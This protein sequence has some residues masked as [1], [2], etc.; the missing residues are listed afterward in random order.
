MSAE[1]QIPGNVDAMAETLKPEKVPQS[2]ELV[3]LAE[4]SYRFAVADDGR[5]FA[6]ALD[7]PNLAR[8]LRGGDGLRQELARAYYR[9]HKRVPS[10]T[11]L[12]DALT[13]VEGI[14]S[15]AD[16]EPLALRVA[17][18]G[19]SIVLDLGTA[20][21]CAVVVDRHGWQ[22]VDRSPVVFRR[23]ELTKALP[24]PV[25][26]GQL[27]ELRHVVNVSDGSW[28]LLAG[29]LV[30]SLLPDIPHPIML[31][32]GL[33]GAGKST[34]AANIAAVVD[35]SAAPLQSPPTD[36]ASWTLNA[37]GSWLVALD[38]LSGVAG[39]LSD[40]LCR[41]VTGD[42]RVARQLYSDSSLTVVAIRRCVLL[43]TIDAGALRGDLA[44]RLL[45]VELERIAPTARRTDAELRRAADDMAPRVLGSLLDLLA[46]VLPIVGTVELRLKPRMADFA[47][48]L[49]AI[50]KVTGSRSLDTYMAQSDSLA[51]DVVAD[52]PVASAVVD[53]MS[54]HE[55]WTGTPAA[56]LDT[57]TRRTF[58]DDKARRPKQWPSTAATLSGALK[59]A[60][61][62]LQTVGVIV[63]TGHTG[64]G[65]TKQ[66]SV[67]L[68]RIESAPAA[69][70]PPSPPS[71]DSSRLSLD[72][73]W[74]IPLPPAGATAEQGLFPDG[75]DGDDGDDSTPAV[76]V[77]SWDEW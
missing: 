54:A 32:T 49:A 42:A 28:P 4:G 8:P 37:S 74:G 20:D 77:G 65:S 75:D 30:A 13:T 62:Q 76:S 26:G 40:A 51:A 14:A 6:V 10:A 22:V 36:A 3:R 50:D 53:L 68:R 44:E 23:T 11:A 45:T 59:R 12:A 63:E 72:D 46:Q 67:T 66:R 43:T 31:L 58:P 71:P 5:T 35:P 48:V 19:D 18:H 34:A 57:L 39:W 64:R 25:S 17:A 21:G 41:A 9:Q 70:S 52:D 24:T 56:L 47:A 33:Q 60:T 15:L 1:P 7:G 2:T 16:R 38:N 69:A 73:D 27:D 61:V 55:H 29:W